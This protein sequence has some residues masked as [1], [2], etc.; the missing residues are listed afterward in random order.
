M[1]VD[2]TWFSVNDHTI[3]DLPR[4]VMHFG[5]ALPW[6]LWLIRHADP[7]DGPVYPSKYDITD[8]FYWVF[9]KANDA[10]QLDI[11]MPSYDNETPLLAI[12][13]SLTMGWTNLPP[14]F[15]AVSETAADLANDCIAQ[16]APLPTNCMEPMASVHDAW[17]S[18][19]QPLGQS[20]NIMLHNRQSAVNMLQ[21]RQSAVNTL[22]DL[23]VPTLGDLL[24]PAGQSASS[25]LGAIV[26]HPRDPLAPTLVDLLVPARQSTEVKLHMGRS[27]FVV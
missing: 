27:Y 23:L 5:G 11:T 24:V 25:M 12:P 6:I 18:S 8:G 20:T 19:S 14:T 1:I 4:E 10:L 7:S 17:A 9:L 22:R 16:D 21:H 13:L 26:L 15:C 2:H 3:P